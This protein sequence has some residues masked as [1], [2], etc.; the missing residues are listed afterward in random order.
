MLQ[1]YLEIGKM[2]IYEYRCTACE[3]KF[4]KLRPISKADDETLCPVCNNNG[5]RILSTFA[6]FS[7]GSSGESSQLGAVSQAVH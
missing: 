6:A 3:N 2:P 1:S 4:E 7:K 5:Q